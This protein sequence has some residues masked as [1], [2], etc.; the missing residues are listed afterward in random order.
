MELGSV[1]L[2]RIGFFCFPI[3]HSTHTP[4]YLSLSI[5]TLSRHK[6]VQKA[7]V[8]AAKKLEDATK[9]AEETARAATTQAEPGEAQVSLSGSTAVTNSCGDALCHKDENR[10]K[11]KREQNSFY[12]QNN[13]S[14]KTSSCFFETTSR[15]FVWC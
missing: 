5:M 11:P 1:T 15:N 3:K 6:R 8:D 7:A 14:S 12:F 2:Q 4:R 9:E 13:N 10:R